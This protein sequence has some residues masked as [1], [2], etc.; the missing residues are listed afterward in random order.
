MSSPSKQHDVSKFNQAKHCG[1][2]LRSSQNR[3]LGEPNEIDNFCG[4]GMGLQDPNVWD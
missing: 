4:I 3:T 1:D 2:F